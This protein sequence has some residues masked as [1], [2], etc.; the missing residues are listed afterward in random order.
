MSEE[1]NLYSLSS[2]NGVRKEVK[3]EG[4]ERA[5]ERGPTPAWNGTAVRKD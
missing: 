4:K 2:W 5:G 3:E 1:R